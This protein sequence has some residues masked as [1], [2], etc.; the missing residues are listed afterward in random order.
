MIPVASPERDIAPIR[1]EIES[2]IQR[3]LLRGNYI[4]GDE[5]KNFEQAF[6][7][8]LG[9][10]YAIGVGSGTDALFLSLKESGIGPGEEVIL[11]A[12]TAI[13]TAVAVIMTLAVPV[14]ADV[15]EKSLTISIDAVK[16]LIT[17]RTR[18]IVPVHLYGNPAN[19]EGL[20]ALADSHGLVL[21]EDAS[22]AHGASYSG[23]KV[24]TFGHTGCF[25]FYPT[26]NLGALGDGGM[27]V[28]S[29]EEKARRIQMLRDYGRKERDLFILR[30][31]NS[32][33][34]ELQA[35]ILNV[36]LNYL[37]KNN[38]RRREIAKRY[39]EAFKG[40]GVLIPEESGDAESAYHL[41]V[42][43]I[44]ARDRFRKHL[45]DQ[46]IDTAVHY[47]SAVCDQPVFQEYA[48]KSD[49]PVTRK[50]LEEIVSLPMFPALTDS[51][52]EKVINAVKN[53]GA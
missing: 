47:P 9:A 28:T 38:R 2:V 8:Y 11:P 15:D 48:G 12:L 33:L 22:Q 49:I 35:G 16:S 1:K 52:V 27:I 25:S 29:H 4:L 3:V 13:P 41:F 17:E 5:V 26:K 18:A 50:V 10:G 37:E 46:G 42:A 32:R 24:G 14:F 20:C 45:M 43:R 31:I 6:A 53:F 36:R 44:R 23:R 7:R 51:E 30:G 39:R 40:T 19:M 21:V 34:D